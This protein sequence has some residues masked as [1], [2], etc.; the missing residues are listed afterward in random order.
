MATLYRTGNA[1]A[2][3]TGDLARVADLRRD[4]FLHSTRRDTFEGCRAAAQA[5]EQWTPQVQADVERH[6]KEKHPRAMLEV[7]LDERRDD[8]AWEL[9]T[10]LDLGVAAHAGGHPAVW[11]EVL[12]RRS[13]THPEDTIPLYSRQI[14][15][16]LRAAHESNYRQAASD[17]VLMRAAARRLGK[18][19][20]ADFEAF[21]ATTVENNRRR[22][23][24]MAIFRET[25]LC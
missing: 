20:V 17:L 8:E 24:C 2:R 18:H 9:A 10:A 15:A 13:V 14:T 16:V 21:L 23:K 3:T 7:L 25:G 19:A 5:A 4:H 1:S 12:K 11:A 6:L 22:P